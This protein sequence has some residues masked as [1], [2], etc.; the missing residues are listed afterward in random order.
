MEKFT[1]KNFH[2]RH[3][4]LSQNQFFNFYNAGILLRVLF[5]LQTVV[6]VRQ[7]PDGPLYKIDEDCIIFQRWT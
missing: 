1:K 7:G 2:V 5:S 4:K 6:I 3:F